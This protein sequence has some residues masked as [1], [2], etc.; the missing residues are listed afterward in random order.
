MSA[1]SP[2][3]DQEIPLLSTKLYLPAVRQ[4]FSAS[5]NYGV[6]FAGTINSEHALYLIKFPMRYRCGNN[7]ID[8]DC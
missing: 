8:K 7:I 6:V 2:L 3:G 5:S 4:P 1:Q